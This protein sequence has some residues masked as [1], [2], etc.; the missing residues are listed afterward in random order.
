MVISRE[1]ALYQRLRLARNAAVIVAKGLRS[2]APTCSIHPTSHLARDLEAGPYV[3]I[4]RR[5]TLSP[6][7]RIGSYT[8]L[9]SGVAIVGDDHNW[10]DPEQ[11]MQFSGRPP[12]RRTEIG[13]DVWLGHGTIVMRGLRIGDGAIVAAGSVVTKDVPPREIWAGV[14]ARKLRDRFTDS[15]DVDRHVAALARPL[16]TPRF[17]E[18]QQTG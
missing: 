5:C 17:A 2:V 9:A 16:V 8:M 10:L 6:G 18:R 13:A 12:Q 14:P 1:G 7:V 15:A 3:F 11:P 4:G